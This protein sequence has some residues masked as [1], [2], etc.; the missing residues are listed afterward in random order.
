MKRL[1]EDP[2]LSKYFSPHMLHPHSLYAV[3]LERYMLVAMGEPVVEIPIDL[4]EKHKHMNISKEHFD[5]F[6]NLWKE[7][8][9]EMGFDSK[10]VWDSF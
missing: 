8:E 5:R 1:S 6:K 10:D 9:K 4:Y 3:I 2:V 7:C